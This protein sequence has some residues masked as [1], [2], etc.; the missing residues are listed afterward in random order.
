MSVP[1]GVV[2]RGR[3]AILLA[4]LVA[5]GCAAHTRPLAL[6][7]GHPADPSAPGT[8]RTVEPAPLPPA[9]PAGPALYACP[10]HPEV[11]SDAPGKCPKCGMEL[12]QVP[13]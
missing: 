4:A 11:T 3:R 9:P 7:A 6:P 2:A 5:G 8:G 13:R 12:Q 1:E 10:M